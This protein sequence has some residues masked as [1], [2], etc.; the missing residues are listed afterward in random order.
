MFKYKQHFQ[1]GLSET[2]FR[3]VDTYNLLRMSDNDSASNASSDAE[4]A[5]AVEA[6]IEPVADEPAVEPD[7]E[8]E[9]VVEPVVKPLYDICSP[10]EKTPIVASNHM[11]L[12]GESKTPEHIK[13]HLFSWYKPDVMPQGSL[14]YYD[15][16]N[17]I[18]VHINLDKLNEYLDK[19]AKKL[20]TKQKH[21][22]YS[23]TPYGTTF[24]HVLAYM[25]GKNY[26]NNKKIDD[27]FER[28]MSWKHI[29]LPH[30]DEQG[31]NFF[32]YLIGIGEYVRPF[33]MDM[34]DTLLKK[35]IYPSWNSETKHTILTQ[36][37]FP[38]WDV[39]YQKLTISNFRIIIRN[40]NKF[41]EA[42]LDK[43]IGKLSF[44]TELPHIEDF[45]IEMYRLSPKIVPKLLNQCLNST[46]RCPG[47]INVRMKR[48]H[49]TIIKNISPD[50]YKDMTRTCGGP[51]GFILNA[52]YNYLS[53]IQQAIIS[54]N[55]ALV[56]FFM[57]K[58][59]D[60]DYET[61][62]EFIAQ[63]T[64]SI[65]DA[66]YKS[67]AQILIEAGELD[68]I[69]MITKTV[70]EG[71]MV[72]IAEN[73]LESLKPRIN[74]TDSDY[75]CATCWTEFDKEDE[76]YMFPKCGHFPFCTTCFNKINI[77]PFCQP[78]ED[79]LTNLMEEIRFYSTTTFDEKTVSTIKKWDV[80]H[81][82]D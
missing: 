68:I 7:A 64:D 80:S 35:R 45:L 14:D 18:V 61:N 32:N 59:T 6:A 21:Y 75:T 31:W 51:I 12:I 44:N 56:R 76:G 46:G 50:I 54:K 36:N 22:F 13:A 26:H 30:M 20:R 38:I 29:P 67:C 42:H 28:I 25:V 10:G 9:R 23:V 62:E 5:A 63:L 40:P 66:D 3:K 27:A 53:K 8:I 2:F 58:M 34:Y 55:F 73:Y 72:S 37:Y 65:D 17:D 33:V 78:S 52:K 11:K 19:P 41:V 1:Y 60:L 43:I 24:F 47:C 16:V 48:F 74:C 79:K 71:I 82:T 4:F 49:H 77:C 57:T 70:S 15:K 69:K 39:W 81:C